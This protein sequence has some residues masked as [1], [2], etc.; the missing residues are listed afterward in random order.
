MKKLLLI[1]IIAICSCQIVSAQNYA[2]IDTDLQQEMSLRNASELIRIN[3]ILNQ[4]YDQMEMRMKSSMFPKKE[5]RRAYVVG[6]LKRFSAETQVGVMDFLSA[7]SSVSEVQSFWIANFINCYASSEVIEEL[8]LHPDVLIIG[9]D[10]EQNMLPEGEIPTD[11]DPTREITYNVTK[12]KADQVWAL[13]Y[14]GEGV[15]VAIIDT[16]VNYNHHDLRDHMWTHPDYPNH[17]WNFVNNGNNPMDDHSHGSHCAG[18][19]AGDGTAGSQTGMAPKA[20]IMAVKVWNAQGSGGASNMINGIQFAAEKGAHV[21]SMS[22]GLW[23]YSATE[24]EKIQFRNTMINVLNAGVVASIAAGNEGPGGYYPYPAPISVRVPGN[25]PP[26]WLHPDQTTTGGISAVVCVGA[27]DSNDN[28]AGFSSRGPVTWQSIPGFN[29]YPYNPGMGLIRPDVCAPGVNIKSCR[30]NNNTGYTNMDGT[31]MACPGV[32]GVMALLLSKNPELTPAEICEI[33]E[34]TAL[35]LPNPTSPKGNIF[36]SGRVDALEAINAVPEPLQGIV[37]EELVINDIEGNNNGRLNPGETVHL[38][39]SMKNVTTDP[40]TDVQVTFTTTDGLVTI[41]NDTA[42][43]GNF[44]PDEVKTVEN[45]FTITL[46]E[47]AVI[48]HQVKCSLNAEFE[49]NSKEYKISI[50]VYDYKIE[51]LALRLPEN[52]PT[53]SPGETTEMLIYLKNTGDDTA[54]DL[55]TD[56]ATSSNYL[57][58]N[59]KTAYYGHLNTNQYKFRAYSITL[60]PDTPSSETFA[61]ITITATEKLGR[62]TAFSHYLRFTNIGQ[63]PATCN[64]I[65]DLSVEVNTSTATLTWTEP[66]GVTPEKYLIY[67]DDVFLEETTATTYT[68]TDLEAGIY[69]YCVEALFPNGCTSEL[70]CVDAVVPCLIEVELTKLLMGGIEADLTWLPVLEGLKFNVYRDEKIIAVVEGNSYT[71]VGIEYGVEYCYKVSALCTDDIESEP[72]NEICDMI[73]G[74]DELQKNI[75]I[76]PNPANNTLYVEGEG[77][78]TITIYNILGQTIE[79]IE[80]SGNSITTIN[81]ASYQPA[82]YLIEILT[83]NGEKINQ[84]VIISH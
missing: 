82:L 14:E 65:E 26:P 5:A 19:V 29:D 76:Y 11:A 28:I 43:F 52:K 72:S 23:G 15:V 9:H 30:H 21:I 20:L 39:V 22:G 16:G 54:Y 80:T 84:R 45:A 60:A 71:D 24:T 68:Q 78:K 18:T 40:I 61:T 25:C 64:S 49:G 46:S 75:N 34:T 79:T 41:I 81:T 58:L 1:A 37:F 67:C 31:S 56:V 47:N 44:E 42:D 69:H 53:I 70:A 2:K 4:Q 3:I 38:T 50:T 10:K 27:T 12:V 62:K 59:D 57:T 73:V 13:G 6:E 51:L 63:P 83:E 77:L 36:G 55:I 33:L 48:G 17:G 32:A 35:K 8:S 74:I 7:M 66:T